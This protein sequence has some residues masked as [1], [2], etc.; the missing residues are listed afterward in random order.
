MTWLTDSKANTEDPLTNNILR[1]SLV[2]EDL[3]LRFSHD[4]GWQLLLFGEKSRAAADDEIAVV[5]Q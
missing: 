4:G 2:R 3:A 1:Q 5:A